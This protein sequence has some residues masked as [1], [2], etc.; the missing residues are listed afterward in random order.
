[1]NCVP[2]PWELQSAAPSRATRNRQLAAL[3]L[4]AAA[5]VEDPVAREFLRH[6]SAGLIL[7]RVAADQAAG[8]ECASVGDR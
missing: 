4:Q 7:P 3:Y 1:M 8:A 5:R 2:R 6:R